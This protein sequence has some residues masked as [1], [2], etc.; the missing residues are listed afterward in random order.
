MGFALPDDS[1]GCSPLSMASSRCNAFFPP[2]IAA[3]SEDSGA[4]HGQ[5]AGFRRCTDRCNND[6]VGTIG[7]GPVVAVCRE[8]RSARERSN[9]GVVIH[10]CETVA[11]RIETIEKYDLKR[12]V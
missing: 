1:T 8:A 7:E 5:R 12:S 2:G 10:E 9:Q 11:E 3:Q 4:E 6:V